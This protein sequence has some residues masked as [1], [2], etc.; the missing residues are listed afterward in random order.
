MPELN[1]SYPP[2]PSFEE[3]VIPPRRPRND[4][5]CL[6]GC[7]ILTVAGGAIATVFVM[8]LRALFRALGGS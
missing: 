5:G 8:L 1:N 3:Q 7:F 4:A 2:P 6:V